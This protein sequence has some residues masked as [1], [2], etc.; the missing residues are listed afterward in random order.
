MPLALFREALRQ[1]Q[2]FLSIRLF[3][4]SVRIPLIPIIND[5]KS[6]SVKVMAL[7][8]KYFRF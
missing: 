4:E 6:S 7:M 8:R 2:N 5:W 1:I 3:P